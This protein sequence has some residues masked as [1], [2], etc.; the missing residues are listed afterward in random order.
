M[1]LLS[2]TLI[3]G[4][5]S[6]KKYPQIGLTRDVYE[7]LMELKYDL[8]LDSLNEVIIFLMEKHKPKK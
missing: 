4:E 1:L 3:M 7:R 8:R 6:K 2:I 5:H